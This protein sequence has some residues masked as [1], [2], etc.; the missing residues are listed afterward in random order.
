MIIYGRSDATLKVRGVRIGT[1]EIYRQVQRIEEVVES[2]VV[3][4]EAEGDSQIV[5]FVQ[6]TS[7]LQLDP[8]LTAR[9][10][11]QI[12]HGASPRYVPDQ[13]IQVADIPRT[14]TGKVSELAVRAALH[15]EEVKNRASLINP[16][17]VLLFGP[18]CLN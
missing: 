11:A 14:A 15:G 13:V 12:A 5:L 16:D 7:G 9:I 8:T 17:A 3:A 6:L 10:N 2:V 4:R 1:A 18:A